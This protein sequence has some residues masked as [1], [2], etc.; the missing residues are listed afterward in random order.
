[1]SGLEKREPGSRGE[2]RR[3]PPQH[4]FQ[5][6][7]VQSPTSSR[8]RA[9]KAQLSTDRGSRGEDEVFRDPIGVCKQRSSFVS[10]TIR[11]Y[12]AAT[13]I[14]STQSSAFVDI[15]T[16]RVESKPVGLSQTGARV[17]WS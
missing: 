4:H 17:E 14:V 13:S 15:G 3:K 9:Q 2:L 5:Q 10:L 6:P 16:L 1:M 11:T 8:R 7:T 12:L